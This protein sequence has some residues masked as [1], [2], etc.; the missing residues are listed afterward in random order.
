M[1]GEH[2]TCTCK[3]LIFTMYDHNPTRSTVNTICR[4]KYSTDVP[5]IPCTCIY[6]VQCTRGTCMCVHRKRYATGTIVLAVHLLWSQRTTQRHVITENQNVSHNTILMTRPNAHVHI[7]TPT[8]ATSTRRQGKINTIKW[9]LT[10]ALIS[11]RY[12]VARDLGYIKEC[13]NWNKNQ[14]TKLG[15]ISRNYN[16]AAFKSDQ[17]LH[18]VHDWTMPRYTIGHCKLHT[19]IWVPT[20]IV[21]TSVQSPAHTLPPLPNTCYPAWAMPYIA[22]R[23]LWAAPKSSEKGLIP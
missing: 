12:I 23:N 5:I 7:L 21:L 13:F 22:T 6:N 11:T 3:L 19:P 17:Y 18:L 14:C 15:V 9:S 20:I 10:S 16:Q 4:Y 2:C 1:L 8:Y